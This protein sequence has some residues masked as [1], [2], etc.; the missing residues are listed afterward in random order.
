MPA[1]AEA[2]RDVES[3]GTPATGQRQ[4]QPGAGIDVG[5]RRAASPSRDLR[6]VDEDCSSKR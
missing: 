1:V 4:P 6:G 3:Q 2:A 5:N